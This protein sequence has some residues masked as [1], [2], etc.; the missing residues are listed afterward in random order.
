MELRHIRY[1][2]AIG[3]EQHFSRA[4]QRVGIAQSPLSRAIRALERD[5]GVTLLNR[6]TRGREVG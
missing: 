1:F 2:I 3:E 4:A 6:T 5:L